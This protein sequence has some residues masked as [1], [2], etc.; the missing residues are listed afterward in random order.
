VVVPISF[1][2]SLPNGW[3]QFLCLI[4]LRKHALKLKFFLGCPV[5]GCP[6]QSLPIVG[7]NL[8]QIF[9]PSFVKCYT[10][11]IAKQQ[12]I[13]LSPTVRSKDCIAISRM[14]F[15]HAALRRLGPRSYLLYSWASVHS[16][17]K[18]T[19]LSWAEAV[20]GTPIVLPNKILQGDEFS[21]DAIV[22]KFLKNLDAPAFSLPRHNS[23]TQLPAEL[24]DELLRAPLIWLRRGDVIPP[25]HCPYYSPYAILR[26]GPCFTTR[27]G[28]WDQIVSI[29]HLKA[30]T[31]AD[32]T[33]SS[34]RRHGR[35]PG[36]RPGSPAAT[37]WVS[38]SD[39]LVSFLPLLRRR[40]AMVQELFFQ[41]RTGFLHALDQWR[42]PSLQSRGTCTVS[43]HR[44]RDWEL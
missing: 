29:S 17:R 24:P 33:P 37:K 16:P 9:G 19:G 8:L 7:R 25:L 41:S 15:T 34:P 36:K 26:H 22:N 23:S 28:S 40:Q 14:R 20:F 2:L 1:S 11:H 35:P 31:E 13:I 12:L 30:Y 38:L 43:G 32:A 6:K 42:H 39:P 3:K 4:R 5:L 10:F 44:L 18:D 21:V 27:V